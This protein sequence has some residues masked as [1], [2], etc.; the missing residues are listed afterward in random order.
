MGTIF[1]FGVLKK[2]LAKMLFGLNTIRLL[3][4]LLAHIL[5]VL[6]RCGF[7]KCIHEIHFVV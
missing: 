4:K 1:Y 6:T 5:S 2:K 7:M 3:Q